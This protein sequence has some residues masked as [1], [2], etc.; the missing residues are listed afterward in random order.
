MKVRVLLQRAF[1]RARFKILPFAVLLTM[2]QLTTPR[3]IG[4]PAGPSDFPDIRRL[5]ADPRVM[6]TLSADGATFTEDQTRAFLERAADH[7]K[8][9]NFGLWTFRDRSDSDFVGYGGIKHTEV[10][11]RDVIELA[12]AITSAHWRKG[13]ATEI[14]LASL[15]HAFDVLHLDRIVAFTL[16][17]NQASRAV[18]EHCGFTYNR[19]ITHANLPHVLYVLEA[20]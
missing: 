13:F 9:H 20:P 18:M 12:Y 15:K 5:H 10:E 16:P 1:F 6:A 19:D 7:W 14:S 8:S 4:T 11:G 3:L 17:H 2:H